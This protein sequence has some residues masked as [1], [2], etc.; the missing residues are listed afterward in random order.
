M[1]PT[2]NQYSSHNYSTDPMV[3][4]NDFTDWEDSPEGDN[5][6]FETGK[7]V[8]GVIVASAI[9]ALVGWYFGWP[10]W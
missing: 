10:L 1:A 9:L 8:V 2:P 6:K 3:D 5:E 7:F 4:F